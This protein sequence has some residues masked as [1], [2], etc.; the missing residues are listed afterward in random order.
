LQLAASLKTDNPKIQMTYEQGVQQMKRLTDELKEK[1][2]SGGSFSV[3]ELVI[4]Y[5]GYK[6]HGDYKLSVNNEAPKHTSIV[7]EIFE[8][9]N[10]ENFQAVSHFLEDV[11]ENG[12]NATT[13]VF[14]ETFKEKIYW[15]T[16]QEE[17]NYPQPG[18][19]GRRL[20]FQR[21]YEAALAKIG[22]ADIEKVL[23]RTNHKG[24]G[25]PPLFEIKNTKIP[26]FYK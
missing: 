13:T 12:L 22:Q 3:G 18:R 9:T 5:P 10:S 25:R 21:Y 17:I 7:K 19:S 14:S 23:Y 11:Y 20:P 6:Q 8:H 4:D 26:T 1:G 24:K 15:I 16:L 2:E